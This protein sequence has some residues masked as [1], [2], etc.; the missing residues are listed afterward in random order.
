MRRRLTEPPPNSPTKMRA[1]AGREWLLVLSG[2]ATLM[3]GD[4]HFRVETNWAAE[5]PTMMPHAIGAEGRACD[6]LFI[7]DR[8]ARRGH[9]ESDN[10]ES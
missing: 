6:V 9:R 5:F 3:L 7:Y 2:T 1:H 8:D 4:R 10:S